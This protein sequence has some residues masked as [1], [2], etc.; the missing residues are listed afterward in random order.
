MNGIETN[1][2]M[3]Q[4]R[5][6]PETGILLYRNCHSPERWVRSGAEPQ[7]HS[8]TDTDPTVQQPGQSGLYLLTSFTTF[9]QN[10]RETHLEQNTLH[11][12]SQHTQQNYFYLLK[13]NK[14]NVSQ[15]ASFFF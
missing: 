5:L 4:N 8:G 3:D 9:T 11:N 2:W 1:T 15:K 10:H 14:C 13:S 7:T 6:A 12:S